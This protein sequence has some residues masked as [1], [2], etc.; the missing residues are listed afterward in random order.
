MNLIITIFLINLLHV[1]Q[2]Q[3]RLSTC[4][5]AL[6]FAST[7]TIKVGILH[8][9]TGTMSISE[10]TL[11]SSVLLAIEEINLKGGVIG[12]K[13]DVVLEDGASDWP[14]FAEK[15]KKLIDQDRVKVIFCCWTSASRKAVLPVVEQKDHMLFYPVQYEGQE[16]S[17][18]IFYMGAAPN[19]QLN[20]AVIYMNKMYPGLNFFLL[21]SDYLYPRIANKIIKNQVAGELKL[22][23]Q[24]FYIPL[25]NAEVDDA[26][27]AIKKFL[28]NGGIIFNTLNGDTNMAFF[29][30][31]SKFLDKD[32]YPII[33]VSVSEV[34]IQ[35]IGAKYIEGSYASWNYFMSIQ[36]ADNEE[37][38]KK[39]Q[40]K[41]GPEL[42]VNDPM[43]A[44]YIGVHMWKQAVEEAKTDEITQVR[45]FVMGQ[46]FQAAEGLVTVGYNHHLTK[47]VRIGKANA[48]G[49]FDIEMETEAIPAQPWNQWIPEQFDNICDFSRNG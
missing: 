23:S 29:T 8:S 20:P 49:Q 36:S 45:K 15:A 12:K 38:I 34:E 18:N 26:F 2:S 39:F 22:D 16:C 19:Q 32:K 46:T 3:S 13:I 30:K 14:T 17:K 10:K 24:E 7:E 48:S 5:D 6:T 27:A 47:Y 9:L 25:G 42:I 28:P 31:F 21:G 43:E 33:S 41:Y 44:S 37:F 1:H 11:V 35:T 40:N 4:D